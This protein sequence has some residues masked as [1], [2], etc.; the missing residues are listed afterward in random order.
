LFFAACFKLRSSQSAMS[1]P[2]Q[3]PHPQFVESDFRCCLKRIALRIIEN[4]T[5]MMMAVT[6]PHWRQSFKAMAEV[7]SGEMVYESALFDF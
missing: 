1:Q 3:P 6:A 2:E 5:I 4:A 7:M